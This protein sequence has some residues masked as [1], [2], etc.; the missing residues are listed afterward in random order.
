MAFI[1]LQNLGLT[2][3]PS[4]E[5]PS[6]KTSNSDPGA[7]SQHDIHAPSL[8]L[9][10]SRPSIHAEPESS[11]STNPHAIDAHN[12]SSVEP[13]APTNTIYLV[14]SSPIYKIILLLSTRFLLP[15]QLCW[16]DMEPVC[17]TQASRSP[18][19]QQAMVEEF[20]SLIKQGTWT[21]VPP[22]PQVNIVGCKW[23][24]KIKRHF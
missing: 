14:F 19:W 1:L 6:G 18:Y 10:P 8:A 3:E 24:F 15:S 16:T 5:I 7:E 9:Q 2:H 23:V 11:P 4:L 22:P 20:N 12:S 21:S 13:V 17:Y